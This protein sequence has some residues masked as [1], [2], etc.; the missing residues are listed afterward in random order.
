[1]GAA[2][3]NQSDLSKSYKWTVMKA[4]GKWEKGEGVDDLPYNHTFKES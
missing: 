3:G 2:V 4:K 1:M